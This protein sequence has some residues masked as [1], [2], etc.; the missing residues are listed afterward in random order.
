MKRVVD[1]LSDKMKQGLTDYVQNVRERVGSMTS[2]RKETTSASANTADEMQQSES[3]R[4]PLLPTDELSSTQC[5]AAAECAEDKKAQSFDS[6]RSGK[7]YP[8]VVLTALPSNLPVLQWPP[9]IWLLKP[10][11]R[12]TDRIKRKL[13]RRFPHAMLF[14][15]APKRSAMKKYELKR[16]TFWL[17]HEKEDI[18]LSLRLAPEGECR[19]IEDAMKSYH[20]KHITCRGRK[21]IHRREFAPSCEEDVF[22]NLFD[23]KDNIIFPANVHPRA[24]GASLL[25][26]DGIHPNNM[27]YDCW[28]RMIADEILKKWR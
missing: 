16:G 7:Q 1:A 19:R 22:G 5:G 15:E 27:G 3:S 12:W 17:E 18:F 4:H 10:L 20:E 2:F 6:D 21:R 24:P 14:V 9:F 11:I 23:G 28:G 13:A 26:A 25:S 8:L